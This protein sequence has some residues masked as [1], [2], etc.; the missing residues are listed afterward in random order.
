MFIFIITSG[1]HQSKHQVNSWKKLSFT[2]DKQFFIRPSRHFIV[3]KWF[4]VTYLST[5]SSYNPISLK[6]HNLININIH[7]T[8][9]SKRKCAKSTNTHL[10]FFF[11]FISGKCTKKIWITQIFIVR[12][13]KSTVIPCFCWT[14]H[15]KASTTT[16]CGFDPCPHVL[17][18]KI[19][20]FVTL[21][22]TYHNNHIIIFYQW[23]IWFIFLLL[24]VVMSVFF[25]F[26][27]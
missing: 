24:S 19:C 2:P 14:L 27:K 12:F 4:S 7:S 8:V 23:I 15:S 21:E 17:R 26:S 25:F 10:L 3:K 16:W 1:I 13:Y 5:N 6:P 9:F 18:H 22:K 20:F 11:L